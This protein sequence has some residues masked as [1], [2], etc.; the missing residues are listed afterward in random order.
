MGDFAKA[1]CPNLNGC[2]PLNTKGVAGEVVIRQGDPGVRG[3]LE[4]GRLEERGHGAV[5]VLVP[6]RASGKPDSQ[7]LRLTPWAL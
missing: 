3:R 6:E 5:C 7:K 1:N 4:E 2:Y